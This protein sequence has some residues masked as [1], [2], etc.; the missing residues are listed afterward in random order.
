MQRMT[1]NA[2]PATWAYGALVISTLLLQGCTST[3]GSASFPFDTQ[4]SAEQAQGQL[5]PHLKTMSLAQGCDQLEKQGFTCETAQPVPGRA[6]ASVVCTLAPSVPRA[7][8]NET[9]APTPVTWFVNLES[10]DG[11]SIFDVQVQRAPVDLLD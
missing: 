9:A 8:K 5:A 7:T 1:T 2:R 3:A 4:Q 10:T 11:A 6:V